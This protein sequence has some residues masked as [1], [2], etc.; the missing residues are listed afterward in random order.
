M[1]YIQILKPWPVSFSCLLHTWRIF[2]LPSLIFLLFL[3]DP[4]L[5]AAES[6]DDDYRTMENEEEEEEEEGEEETS[7]RVCAVAAKDEGKEEESKHTRLR[8]NAQCLD[9]GNPSWSVK[10]RIVPR[11]LR[12]GGY[13]CIAGQRLPN[14]EGLLAVGRNGERPSFPFSFPEARIVNSSFPFPSAK[15]EKNS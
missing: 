13:S 5:L 15:S 8:I 9:Y 3:L 10:G 14:K 11:V 2:V 1:F 7:K 6:R 4:P 12:R